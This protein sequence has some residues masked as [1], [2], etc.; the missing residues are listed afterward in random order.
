MREQGETN[1]FQLC[2]D[3]CAQ[4]NHFADVCVGRTRD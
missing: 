3:A 2:G 4:L 1:R